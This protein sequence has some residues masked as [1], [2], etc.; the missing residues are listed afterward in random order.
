[1]ADF[2]VEELE[3]LERNIDR[4]RKGII[5]TEDFAEFIVKHVMDENKTYDVGGKNFIGN[6]LPA[7]ANITPTLIFPW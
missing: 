2:T 1:M 4:E 6:W 3:Q 7:F 5:A